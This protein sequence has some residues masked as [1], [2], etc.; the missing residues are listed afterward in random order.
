MFDRHEM[1]RDG[2]DII[3]RGYQRQNLVIACIKDAEIR[4]IEAELS[5]TVTDQY[6]SVNHN[7]GFS[8][9]CFGINLAVEILILWE[10]FIR[11][12]GSMGKI[13]DRFEP[14]YRAQSFGRICAPSSCS[15]DSSRFIIQAYEGHSTR[16]LR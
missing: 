12:C 13:C 5:M 15:S 4:Y 3:I 2:G 11:M 8:L 1:A 9:K 14:G 10:N 6:A 7:I 16:T